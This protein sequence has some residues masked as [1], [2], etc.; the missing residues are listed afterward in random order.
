MLPIFFGFNAD[1]DPVFYLNAE[2]DQDP[3]RQTNA[4]PDGSGP[5]F[6]VTKG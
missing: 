2:P 5:W 4:D 1:P 3:G 6:C